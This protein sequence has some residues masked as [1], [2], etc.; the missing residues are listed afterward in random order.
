[1]SRRGLSERRTTHSL[2]HSHIHCLFPQR[3]THSLLTVTITS[4]PVP[5]T[6]SAPQSEHRLFLTRGRKRRQPSSV[7]S[8]QL[9]AEPAA[10]LLV[11]TRT[12]SVDRD[13]GSAA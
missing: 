1:M 7:R 4:R 13:V 12:W 5:T 9:V 10:G 2:T 6:H 11:E 3:V 8:N